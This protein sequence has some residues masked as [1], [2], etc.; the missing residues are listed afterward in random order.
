MDAEENKTAYKNYRVEWWEVPGRDENWKNEMIR[1][2]PGGEIEFNQE[3]ACEFLGSSYTLVD[4]NAL[5]RLKHSQPLINHPYDK[6]VRIYELPKKGSE[7]IIVGDGA[8][9]GGDAFAFHII[10]ISAFPLKQVACANLKIPYLKVP[11]IL[12]NI[13]RAYNDAMIIL[14]NN[15]GAGTSVADLLYQVYE[16]ENIFKENDKKWLGF[17]T[18][19][20]NRN[21]ILTHLKLFIENSKLIIKDKDTIGQL[22]NFVQIK[23][24]YQAG[25]GSNDDLVMSL[26][27]LFAPYLDINNFENYSQFIANIESEDQNI[28]DNTEVF[29]S[30]YMDEGINMSTNDTPLD[31]TPKNK[32]IDGYYVVSEENIE[33]W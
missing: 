11:M 5:K 31:T 2:L 29:F 3:Y 15:E 23:G 25:M 9:G 19:A 1:T 7:Y 18:T 26:A 22:F 6:N 30:G 28:E 16:Y 14:E 17:R 24:K 13:G 10:D 33:L 20:G 8:K 27:L 12:D 21:K 32:F 4:I